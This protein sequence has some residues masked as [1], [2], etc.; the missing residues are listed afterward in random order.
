MP[1]G[2][3]IKINSLTDREIIDQLAEA[4]RAGVPVDLIVRGICCIL[5]GVPE[6]TERIRVL[7]IVG[8]FLEHARVYAFGKGEGARV[9]ISSADLMTRNTERRVE[10][11]C[12]ILDRGIRE[13]LLEI[14]RTQL[15]DSEK[16]RRMLSDGKY[17]RVI[18]AEAGQVNCQEAFLREAE[19]AKRSA[20][21]PMWLKRLAKQ[22]RAIAGA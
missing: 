11:A 10:I 7:S 1:C 22:L 17:E 19:L 8:R 20:P 4:S 16:A 5:P 2:I 6:K 15:S 3:L 18:A 9:Y 14:L 12:P 13:R 21:E